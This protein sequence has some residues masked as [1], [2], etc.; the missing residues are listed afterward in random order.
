MF[1]PFHSSRLTYLAALGAA[2]AALAVVFAQQT[3]NA[4]G[5]LASDGAA[6]DNFGSSVSLSGTIGLVG[7]RFDNFGANSYQGSAY[8]FRNLDTASGTVNEDVKLLA[9]DGYYGDY[10]G[11][12]VSLSGT[13]ALVGLPWTTS[14][15][16]ASYSRTIKARPISSA[17]STPPQA[18]STRTSSSSPPTAF[19][20]IISAVP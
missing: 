9:S 10:F 11:S 4:A 8:L 13:T 16:L 1:L 12:S 3:V 19:P 20:M 2:L 17:T 14:T 15:T 5:L 6:L 7:A 18:R